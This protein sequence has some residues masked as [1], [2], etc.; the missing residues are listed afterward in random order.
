MRG[1]HLGADGGGD[2]PVAGDGNVSHH[3]G[4]FGLLFF[5]AVEVNGAGEGRHHDELGEGDAG[6]EGHLDGGV[7]GGGLV[8]GEAED[9]GAED[10][11]AVLLECL[12]LAGQGFTGVVEVFKDGLE[13]FGGDGFYADECSLDVGLAHGVEVLAVFAGF[14]G[15]L[16][17][18]DH[19]FGELGE[20]GHEEEAFGADGGEFGEFGLVVLFACEAE[21]GE[22]DGIE[23]V[24]GEGDEAE[25]DLAE[26]D[27]LVD[28]GLVRALAGLL[29]VGAPD[30]AEGTV[31]GAAADGLDGGPHVFVAGH[32]V[33]AGGEEVGTA[34]ASAFVDL[35]RF[36]AGEDVGDGFAPG[37]VAVAFDHGVSVASFEGFFGKERGVDAAVDDPG[38]ALAGDATDLV[39]AE[40][41]AGVNA[42]ADDV[43]GLDG[44]GDDLLDGFVDE[45]GVAC[46]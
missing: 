20:L 15:D 5:P 18:E 7:E 21:V 40:G 6:F 35:F 46:E 12:E 43:A 25:A 10:V 16:G 19:I 39:A 8:G 28:D 27:D 24:V 11:D 37:D 32:E 2:E 26:V 3:F 9:E 23:V 45:D 44:F 14:H 22:G 1:E 17:E 42:D 36:R 30:A 29:A 34:D 33:P 13:T 31:L 4:R 38:T 41:V